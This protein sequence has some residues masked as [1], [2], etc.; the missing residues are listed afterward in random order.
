MNIYCVNEPRP[1]EKGIPNFD[2]LRE[3]GPIIYVFTRREWP[4]KYPADS[5]RLLDQRLVGFRPMIDAFAFL[6]GDPFALLLIGAWAKARNIESVRWMRY[7]S[8][9]GAVSFTPT[10]VALHSLTLME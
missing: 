7:E 1:L 10:V 2:A 6:G 5:L 4:A 8:S 9:S 3:H